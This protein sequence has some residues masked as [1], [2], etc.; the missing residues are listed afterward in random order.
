MG[1]EAGPDVPEAKP[2]ES[3]PEEFV[4][5]ARQ[6]AKDIRDV[7]EHF[8]NSYVN[9][10]RK[11]IKISVGAFA[12]VT[13]VAVVSVYASIR[14]ARAKVDEIARIDKEQAATARQLAEFERQTNTTIHGTYDLFTRRQTGPGILDV[15]TLMG[16]TVW[17]VDADLGTLAD[18][19]YPGMP[20]HQAQPS[21]A[22]KRLFPGW[23][24]TFVD[25][26]TKKP[27]R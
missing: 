7:V 12:V 14:I 1:P 10:V 19:V 20:R 9:L 22:M 21:D 3:R 26:K 23:L 13:V 27:K 4:S 25:P 6:A 17:N 15:L 11:I 8:E 16:S 2:P 18:K 24:D 5:I